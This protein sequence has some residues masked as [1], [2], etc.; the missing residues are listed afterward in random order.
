[1]DDLDEEDEQSR[2]GDD[3]FAVFRTLAVDGMEIHIGTKNE[4]YLSI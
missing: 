2:P 1:M 4:N 3:N